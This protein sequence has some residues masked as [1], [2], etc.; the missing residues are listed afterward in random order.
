MGSMPRI[1]P[2]PASETDRALSLLVGGRSDIRARHALEAFAALLHGPDLLR[3][4][5]RW[6]RTLLGPRAAGLVVRNP[7][8]TAMIFHTPADRADAG[9]LR[10]LLLE[11]SD[12]TLSDGIISFVQ[13][14]LEPDRPVDA[15]AL[16]EAGFER[17]TQLLYM[18]RLVSEAVEEPP[19]LE[20]EWSQFARGDERELGGVIADTY[21]DSLDCP[22]LRGK[23][24]LPDVIASHRGTGVYRPQSWWMPARGGER[25]GCVLVN[26]VPGEPAA[27]EIVY[28]GVR[29]AFRRRGLGRALIRHALADAFARHVRHVHLAVDSA[30]TPAAALYQSEGFVETHRRDVFV[31]CAPN[32]EN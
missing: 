22:R 32:L 27:A 31:K 29:P 14:L 5:F 18:T 24:Q 3:C 10:R 15:A 7:G 2:V 4:D 19:Q 12:A 23:R 1:E 11:L 20:L 28:L 16:S 30:N 25:V 17:L 13:A 26:G 6:A 8:N 21:V 9:A